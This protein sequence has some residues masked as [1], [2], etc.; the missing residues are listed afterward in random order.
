MKS[1]K[2]QYYYLS[3]HLVDLQLILLKLIATDDI[4]TRFFYR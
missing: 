2:V 4:I 1:D 3:I